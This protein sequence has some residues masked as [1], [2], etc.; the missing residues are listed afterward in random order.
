M[1]PGKHPEA[2]HAT[3]S[4]LTFGVDLI[5]HPAVEVLQMSGGPEAFGHRARL[6]LR[7]AVRHAYVHSLPGLCLPILL[8]G[9][10][11]LAIQRQIG[12]ARPYSRF[13]RC[14]FSPAAAALTELTALSSANWVISKPGYPQGLMRRKGSR[15]ALTL[16]A[17]P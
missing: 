10:V 13:R 6:Q 11:E 4:L 12:Y 15:S 17:I 16:R 3:R 9:S 5:E 14:G 8:E 7:A 1:F 2:A